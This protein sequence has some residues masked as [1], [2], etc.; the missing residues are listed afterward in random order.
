MNMEES[1][2]NKSSHEKKTKE[3]KNVRRR[4]YDALNVLIASG[5]LKKNA[6]K[7]VLYEEKPENRMKGLKLVIKKKNENKKRDLLRTI[8]Y[9]RYNNQDKRDRLTESLE[10]LIAFRKLIERNKSQMIHEKVNDVI[11]NNEIYGKINEDR[12]WNSKEWSEFVRKEIVEK[13]QFPLIILGTQNWQENQINVCY[14]K[15]KNA[16]ALSFRKE[17]SIIGDMDM[18]LKLGFQRNKDNLQYTQDP[19]KIQSLIRDPIR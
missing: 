2:I 14:S 3:E 18:L 8:D 11:M 5:V 7:N 1:L 15:E 13:I 19:Y 9:R 12:S 10:K 6:N 16:L 17:F 4:V